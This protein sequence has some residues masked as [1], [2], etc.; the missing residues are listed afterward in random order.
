MYRLVAWARITGVPSLANRYAQSSR[1]QPHTFCQ[2]SGLNPSRRNECVGSVMS[3]HP[4]V[5][6]AT[7]RAMAFHRV[8][9]S[10]FSSSPDLPAVSG[11]FWHAGDPDHQPSGGPGGSSPP[12]L[13][14]SDGAPALRYIFATSDTTLSRNRQ[15]LSRH[16]FTRLSL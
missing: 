11:L 8:K 6:P 12:R 14:R 15:V 3:S 5:L 9:N 1:P 7:L 16:G 13:R 4:A 10:R 2:G